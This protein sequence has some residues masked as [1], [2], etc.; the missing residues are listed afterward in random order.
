MIKFY[1]LLFL[2]TL[3]VSGFSVAAQTGASDADMVVA[4]DGSGDF[5]SLQ[6]AINSAPSNSQRPT[7]IYIKRGL[8]DT[9]KLFIPSDKK[10][11]TL[12]G[13]SRDETIISY[14]IYDCS[15]GKCPA[16]DAAKWTGDNIR[17]SAT[18]TI[19][20]EGFRAENLTIRNTAGPVGQ[21]QAIT[22]RSDKTVFI[23]CQLEGYQDTIYFWNDG[24]RAYFRNCLVTGR[25]DY[26][27]GGGIA[28]F[29]AC[30]IRSWGGGWI[31]A[32][33]TE[34]AEDYGFVFYECAITY[35]E[36]SP[37]AGDDGSKIRLGRPW[38]NYP[39]VAWLYC[40]FTEMI[41][42]EGWGDTWN[43]DYAAT[44][45]QLHLYEYKNTGP[46]ADMSQRA[47]WAGLRALS[48]DEALNYTA[49]KVLAGNDGW[50]PAA[51]KPLT[52]TFHFEG[53]NTDNAWL[54]S[55]NWNP[56]SIPATGSAALV[57][58]NDTL[59]ANGGVFSADLLL[60]EKAVLKLTE[61]STVNYL[62]VDGATII[63][64][65][66]FSLAGRLATRDSM[67]FDINGI[68]TLNASISGVHRLIKKGKGKLVLNSNNQGFSGDVLVL[69]GELEASQ[70]ASLGKGKLE[71]K[72]KAVLSVSH[73]L[74]FQPTSKLKIEGSAILNLS[75]TLTTSEFF[76]DGVMQ[77]VASYTSASHPGI[78]SGEG[79]VQVGRPSEFTFIGGENGSWDNPAHFVPSLLPEA[80]ETVYCDLE[81]ETTSTPFEAN[82]VLTSNGNMRLR[83]SDH[84][85]KGSLTMHDGTSFR[86]NTGGAG[87]GF[88]APVILEG[89]IFMIMES[90]NAAGSKMV[91]PGSFTGDK[92]IT[93]I[94]NGKGTLNTGTV[95]LKGDNSAFA[96][97]WDLTAG[98]Q[99]YPGE[100]YISAIDGQAENAFGQGYI[101]VA[102]GNRVLISHEKA[103]PAKLSIG[104]NGNAKAVLNVDV[105]LEQ[106]S[107]NDVSLGDGRYNAESHPEWFEG[108][109][110][111][112]VGTGVSTASFIPEN[113]L[114]IQDQKI[115]INGE[116]SE[117]L[118]YSA[119]GQLMI[120]AQNLNEVAIG[121][122]YQGLYIVKYRID[123]HAGAIKHLVK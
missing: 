116:A 113:L 100:A 85:C 92:V 94:N 23:N 106:L 68:L 53:G 10:N 77:E 117:V 112:I 46:G 83:G 69:E 32:P 29:D 41:H 56:Q 79:S 84:V 16:D 49:E 58:G 25:T 42:P 97:T 108:D 89:D 6:E 62:A 31:T 38:H 71:V 109:G 45:D 44:S 57:A 21:A 20:G 93:V 66:V 104:L 78:I 3:L 103:V 17:T 91:L 90:G 122:L 80:G 36:N 110:A 64:E 70:E 65:G 102:N 33:S 105:S 99:K 87:F 101:D 121:D 26:I 1:H 15:G 24:L 60:R 81:M 2:L 111:L 52:Q 86:Y 14:H 107:I 115:K 51:E 9:E 54:D 123:G 118:V 98:S 61:N 50:N 34:A 55:L 13:E 37:R 47:N 95:V 73:S 76:I 120:K 82:I 88:T 72:D 12:V 63:S 114:L 67:V 27:Y 4:L 43:M 39:K 5:V 40:Q 28:F 35:A 74:A 48:D 8:Y 59:N 18:L 11:I 75:A 19:H 22:V 119:N 7:V 96:G 30:E